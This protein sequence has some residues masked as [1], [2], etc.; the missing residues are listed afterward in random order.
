MVS[1]L[2]KFGGLDG[3]GATL[4]RMPRGYDEHH[5]AAQWLK[6][7]SFTAGRVIPESAVTSPKLSAL[8]ESEF[9]ALLPLVR[10]LNS[11]LGY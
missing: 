6:F 2:K 5:P 9:K 7:Q 11:A 4:K 1:G 3:D 10:W 8:L